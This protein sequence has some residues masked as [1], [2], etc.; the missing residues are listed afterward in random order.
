MRYYDKV[1]F[2]KIVNNA[3]AT[4]DPFPVED[5][6]GYCVQALWIGALGSGSIKLQAS[7]DANTWAD[8]CTSEVTIAGGGDQLWNVSDVLYKWLR[9]SVT[10]NTAADIVMGVR[11]YCKGYLP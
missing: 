10:S 5:M 7:L 1:I 8:I 4:S 6:Y 3:T 9:V 2:N 11:I